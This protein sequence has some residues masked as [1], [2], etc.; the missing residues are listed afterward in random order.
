MLQ[1]D[2]TRQQAATELAAREQE[3]SDARTK[4]E[5]LEGN[6]A[7]DKPQPAP[8]EL[9]AREQ[10]VAKARERVERAH[11]DEAEGHSLLMVGSAV[12]GL[13]GIGLITA[14]MLGLTVDKQHVTTAG[15]I[16][17][18]SA[19]AMFAVVWV[20]LVGNWYR[21]HSKPVRDE[22]PAA[23]NGSRSKSAASKP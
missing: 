23:S 6:E 14:A 15:I 4:L 2:D 17:A 22:T 16:A 7:G 5:R 11:A 13:A 18:I 12:A 21:K 10:E 19:G 8:A 3:L 1:A 9:A 20:A